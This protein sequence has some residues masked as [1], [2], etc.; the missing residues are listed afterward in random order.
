MNPKKM[1]ALE[2]FNKNREKNRTFDLLDLRSV[3]EFMRGFIPFSMNLPESES[4]FLVNLRKIW[5]HPR[6]VVVVTLHP[7]IPKQIQSAIK[8]AGGN[9]IGYLDY[10]EWTQAGY[11]ILSLESIEFDELSNGVDVLIDVRTPS[12]WKSKQI[13]TSQNAPLSDLE[14][15]ARNLN[16]DQ[17]YVAFCAGIYRG[18]NGAA[19]LRSEG[20]HVRYFSNGLN[21]WYERAHIK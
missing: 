3:S 4:D 19:K 16:R 10:H 8:E 7:E 20:L 15:F 21:T 6:N 13:P 1:P 11:P 17:S 18:L 5:P 12:E 9:L 14:G 2:V